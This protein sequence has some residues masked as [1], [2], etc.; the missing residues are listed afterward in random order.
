MEAG[1]M[2]CDAA[3]RSQFLSIIKYEDFPASLLSLGLLFAA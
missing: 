2:C 1:H 3:I